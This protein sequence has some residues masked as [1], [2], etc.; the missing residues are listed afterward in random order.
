[1]EKKS[2]NVLYISIQDESKI[3]E[4]IKLTSYI[5]T[6]D[7]IVEIFANL[8]NVAFSIFATRLA[9]REERK[10]LTIHIVRATDHVRALLLFY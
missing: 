10:C 9:I 5:I 8:S 6:C 1:M 4:N 2:C 7:C 3:R